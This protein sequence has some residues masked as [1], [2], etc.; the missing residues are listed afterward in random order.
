MRRGAEE[1]AEREKEL[2][3][4]FGFRGKG[5]EAKETAEPK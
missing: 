3:R 4:P 5:L 1:I 2:S